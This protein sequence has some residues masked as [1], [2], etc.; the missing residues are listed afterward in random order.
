MS[1]KRLSDGPEPTCAVVARLGALG[2]TLVDGQEAL[3]CLGHGHVANRGD[4]ASALAAHRYT[5][6]LLGSA[7]GSS[8]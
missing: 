6:C 8:P 2:A 1:H 7:I 3:H 4:G 5:N